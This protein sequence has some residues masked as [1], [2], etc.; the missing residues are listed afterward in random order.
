MNSKMNNH[1]VLLVG[2]FLSSRGGNPSVAEELACHLDSMGYLLV[3]TSRVRSRLFRLLDMFSVIFFQQRIYQIA[4]VEVY[5]GMAFI[6]AEMA[7]KFLDILQK[8]YILTLHGGNLPDFARRWPGRVEQLLR[9]AGAITAPSR[10]LQEAMRFYGDDIILLPNPLDIKD[11][12]FRLRSN[13]GPCLIWLRAFHDIYNPQMAPL[14]IAELR[15]SYPDITL[16]MVGPDKGDGALQETQKLI[17]E[18]G[19]QKNIEIVPGIAKSDVPEYLERADI[20]INTTNIDNTPVS[21]LEAM[22]CGLCVVSTDVGGIPYLLEDRQDSLLVSRDNPEI[23]ASAI[24][25]ILMESNLAEN[26]SRNARRKVE[27]F[28]WSV[29]LPQWEALFSGVIEKYKIRRF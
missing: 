4:C 8:P 10:Y 28:D 15:A 26:I 1:G 3:T 29:I 14:V 9:G 12:P 23:M 7:C 19:L 6:W 13:P 25:N 16:I 21:V 11:Y 18:L 27:K 22:A 20:F 2:N 24:K 17:D 5:S